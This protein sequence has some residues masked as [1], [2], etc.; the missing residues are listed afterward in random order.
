MV[1][2]AVEKSFGGS[3]GMPLVPVLRGVSFTVPRGTMMSIV[4]PSGCG[5]STLL[6]CLAGLDPVTAGSVQLL[7]SDLGRLRSG[8]LARL[9]RDR[10]GFVFQSYN[11]V[12]ALNA[13]ENVVLPKRLAGQ[14]AD[15]DHADVVLNSLGLSER[16]RASVN[17]LSNGEQQR[18]ALARVMANAPELVFADEPT[19]ALDSAS[20]RLVLGKLREH[21]SE[22]RTVVMVTHDLDA[23][24]LADHVL[25][26]RD[27]VVTHTLTG[28]T[29]AQILQTMEGSAA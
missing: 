23:A 18:V 17:Q 21:A 3:R 29:S 6:F 11:L 8:A 1:A 4:G 7:G 26:M 27:G 28:A 5:K 19:G 13:R 16:T 9:Y 25:V 10:V 2:N 20:S 22:G 12:S 24:S 14:R 15:L